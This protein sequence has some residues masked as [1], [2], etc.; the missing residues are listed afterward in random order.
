MSET[1]KDR[2]EMRRGSSAAGFLRL[3]G[4]ALS[5]GVYMLIARL[6]GSEG[7]G[8]LSVALGLASLLLIPVLLGMPTG[9]LRWFSEENSQTRRRQIW[10]KVRLLILAT[11]SVAGLLLVLLA[12]WLAH[13]VYEDPRLEFAISAFGF[14]LPFSAFWP[15]QIA[16]LAGLK[17]PGLSQLLENVILGLAGLIALGLL[18]FFIGSWLQVPVLA[19]L[20]S[21]ITCVLVGGVLMRS[22][23]RPC[24][25]EQPAPPIADMLRI[26]FPI[27][28]SIGMLT[29]MAWSD[30]VI[31][32][33]FTEVKTVGIYRLAFKIAA[34]TSI[35]LLAVNKIA[36]PQISHRYS[37]G[38]HVAL[39]NVVR[40][41]VNIVFAVTLPLL[42]LCLMVPDFLLGI[43]EEEFEAG[44]AELRILA[45]GFFV[46]AACGP[47]A[48]LLN[49]T[50]RET[51]LRDVVCI[52]LGLNLALNF[53]LIPPFGSV[54]A[55][56]ATAASTSA[57]NLLA[58]WRVRREFGFWPGYLPGGA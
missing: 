7:L 13:V 39:R 18:W 47:V 53:V 33:A 21:V 45:L 29:I 43:F 54:G 32:G 25:S 20:A 10:R 30:T 15:L 23:L 3:V 36:A 42:L 16:G 22:S 41:A 50:G 48:L 24:D 5:Y 1:Q 11:S 31:L 35:G 34:F 12:P 27:M 14:T 49:M 56:I 6:Y 26:T 8:I 58:A 46:N 40:H 51:Q 37:Q 55:A 52:V 17:R 19:H 2:R 9:L 44:T 4:F 28:L 38:D 57:W